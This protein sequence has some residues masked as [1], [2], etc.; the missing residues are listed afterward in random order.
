MVPLV[1]VSNS[2]PG[3][4]Y[5]ES[6]GHNILKGIFLSPSNNKGRGRQPSY[7]RIQYS[8]PSMTQTIHDTDRK[9]KPVRLHSRFSFPVMS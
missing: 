3:A 5:P 9:R 8:C 1:P 4:N 7:S 2:V 6:N